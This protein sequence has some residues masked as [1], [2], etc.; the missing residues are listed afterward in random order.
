M[1]VLNKEE[2]ANCKD[3]FTDAQAQMRF[4]TLRAM[5]NSLHLDL[6]SVAALMAILAEVSS[7]N[8]DPSLIAEY[9]MACVEQLR[10]CPPMAWADCGTE[11][12]ILAALHQVFDNDSNN[13]Q[14]YGHRYVTSTSN[15]RIEAWW[16]NFRKSRSEW[17]IGLFK[18]LTASGAFSPGNLIQ[19]YCIRYCFMDILQ[20]ELDFVTTTWNEHLI[21]GSTI[22][23]CPSAIPDELFFLSE[24]SGTVFGWVYQPSSI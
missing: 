20:K 3:V 21:R 6:V 5:I 23:E 2:L 19:T 18:D 8:H 16:S 15:Q 9:Y 10:G 14:M 13:Q 24:N 11:N 22:S 4:G 12:G 1:L 7:T 17:W